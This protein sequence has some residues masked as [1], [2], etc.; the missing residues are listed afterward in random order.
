V[1]STRSIVARLVALVALMAFALAGTLSL[2]GSRGTYATTAVFEDVRGLISGASVKA[3][4][5]PVGKVQDIR[6]GPDGLPRVRMAV[7]DDFRLRQGAFADMRMQSNAGSLN[8]YVELIQGKGAELPEDAV[9]GAHR[10]DEPVNLDQALSDLDPA[11]RADVG[12][13]LAA[14][15]R[16]TRRRGGYLARALRY[17]AGS[18]SETANLLDQVAADKEALRTLVG[19]GRRLVSAL[20]RS[21]QD[22][23]SAAD[24]VASLLRVSAGRQRELAEAS[25]LFGPGMA[26]GRATLERFATALPNLRALTADSKPVV[27]EIPATVRVLAPATDA[28]V[29]LLRQTRAMVAEAPAQ[30]RALEPALEAA[31]RLFPLLGPTMSRMGPLLDRLRVFA[32]EFL[33]FFALGA[34]VA[35]NYDANGNVVRVTPIQIE[36]ARHTNVVGPSSDAPGLV[37]RPFL[38]TPGALEGEPWADYE[39]SFI[40]GDAR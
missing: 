4:G 24:H 35:G 15:D 20:A 14:L 3:G 30:L 1:T 5:V 9:L 38:R 32:P 25:R 10:T 22:L 21:P 12:H 8:R 17:S 18:L 7:V 16:A 19:D 23:G 6:F 34:D 2:T 27:D 39:K 36:T 37:Q 40:G 26:A 11:T 33:G 28:I 29:P 13:I 31:E